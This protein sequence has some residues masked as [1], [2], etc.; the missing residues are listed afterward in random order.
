MIPLGILLAILSIFA[1]GAGATLLLWREAQ[2]MLLGEMFAASWLLGAG[3]VS[4]LLAV[5]GMLCAGWLLIALVGAVC[6]GLGWIG[7]RELRGGGRIILGMEAA[8]P[9]E[10][11]LSLLVLAPIAYIAAVSFRDALAWDGLLI[12]ES[13]AHQAFLSGG[14]LPASVF[15]DATRSWTHPSYPL[16]LPFTELWVYLCVGDCHQGALK[17]VLPL[18]HIAAVALLWSGALRL[19][20]RPGVAAVTAM[21]MLFIPILNGFDWGLLHG[22]ADLPLAALYLG[23][24]A[25]VLACQ[26]D[27]SPGAWRLAAAFAALLPWVK[28]EGVILWAGLVLQ[29]AWICGRRDWRRTA[30]FALPGLAVWIGWRLAMLVLEAPQEEV[31]QPLTWANLQ[32]GLTRLGTV[33][34]FMRY[35]LGLLDHWSLLW[36]LTPAALLCV[37]LQRRR[38]APV[39]AAAI[40]LPL[41]FDVIPY[42]FTRLEPFQ[43]HVATSFKRLALQVALV[44]LLSV[45]LAFGSRREV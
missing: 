36:F 42:L 24:V 33:L 1:A 18:F 22:Y 19:H 29:A 4:L 30:G 35:E 6:F 37:A 21:L 31:F 41:A 34:R 28:Q 32:A 23:A 17:S 13:K 7:W 9:W 2:P 45:A 3:V 8:P 27:P 26:R 25:G 15:R 16:Y 40:V 5:G 43:M 39:L 14:V 20:V 38:E 11:W 44:A 10:R 12:W